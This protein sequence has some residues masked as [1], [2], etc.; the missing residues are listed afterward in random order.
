[1]RCV[2][3]WEEKGTSRRLPLELVVKGKLQSALVDLT[4]WLHPLIPFNSICPTTTVGT[5]K[6]YF[7]LLGTHSQPGGYI[8]YGRDQRP[9]GISSSCA[10][11]RPAVPV[12]DAT[13]ATTT[14]VLGVQVPAKH[15][16]KIRQS[17]SSIR[18]NVVQTRKDEACQLSSISLP[19]L[20]RCITDKP[21]LRLRHISSGRYLVTW[22]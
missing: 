6:Y 10:I 1:M 12:N 16:T 5:T 19:N 8:Q 22:E 14:L 2:A 20:P 15:A 21:L 17:T 11:L 7:C 3:A 4:A 13:S 9:R 18:D